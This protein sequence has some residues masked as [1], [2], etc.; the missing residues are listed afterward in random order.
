M[1]LRHYHY[2]INYIDDIGNHLDTLALEAKDDSEVDEILTELG[3]PLPDRAHLARFATHSDALTRWQLVRHRFMPTASLDLLARDENAEI[4]AIVAK[5]PNVSREATDLLARDEDV[6]VRMEVAFAS[7]DMSLSTAIALSQDENEEV[8]SYMVGYH[9]LGD[10]GLVGMVNDP[11]PMVRSMVAMRT[12]SVELMR[13]IVDNDVSEVSDMIGEN[14]AATPELLEVILERH[15]DGPDRYNNPL[16]PIARHTATSV[17]MLERIA[18][19]GHELC[20]MVAKGR[21][22]KM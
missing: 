14:P 21:L 2:D 22:A 7:K 11:S 3:L 10:A 8:R 16:F 5:H 13:H 19:S 20:V 15:I 18:V 17:P 1:K 4:R 6:L 9:L 12:P